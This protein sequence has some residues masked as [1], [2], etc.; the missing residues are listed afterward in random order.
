LF[1]NFNKMPIV[2]DNEKFDSVE[3][4]KTKRGG[5][6]IKLTKE[7]LIEP[8][9]KYSVDSN[10]D[11][12]WWIGW[13]CRNL[14]ERFNATFYPEAF[15]EFDLIPD[16]IWLLIFQRLQNK[17]DLDNLKLVC[18]DFYRVANDLTVKSSFQLKKMSQQR[19][20]GVHTPLSAVI[21]GDNKIGKTSFI[22]KY[23]HDSIGGNGFGTRYF[24]TTPDEPNNAAVISVSAWDIADGAAQHRAC[25]PFNMLADCIVICV[26]MFKP[27]KSLKLMSY[28]EEWLTKTHAI[29]RDT[30]QRLEH[31]PRAPFIVV[32]L[33]HYTSNGIKT[34]KEQI[35][36]VRRKL[37]KKWSTPS[38]YVE[39]DAL[40]DNVDHVFAACVELIRVT[41]NEK[42]RREL[43]KLTI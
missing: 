38:L 41:G 10:I 7:D 4:I 21:V 15:V 39:V 1:K 3:L 28:V 23:L 5:K 20:S 35:N 31:E 17:D 42:T 11:M 34:N 29:T 2:I 22:S 13:R 26:P 18:K 30:R 12:F 33:K 19:W 8:K 32:G 40:A 27:F 36:S 16:E 14:A 25:L 43:S 24:T 37:S 6:R 9:V